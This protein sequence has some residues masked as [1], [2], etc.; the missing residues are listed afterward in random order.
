MDSSLAQAEVFSPREL[1]IAAEVPDRLV[2]Q[3]VAGGSVRTVADGFIAQAEAMRVMRALASG[4]SATPAT[5][6][7]AA[8]LFQCPIHD[9]R[10]FGLPAVA[11]TTVHALFVVGL[12]VLTTVGA[13]RLATE[14]RIPPDPLRLV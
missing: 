1:A 5:P 6:G 8:A 4:Q 3:W 11:S 12:L 14:E 2:A 7:G 10:P 9:T 13:G